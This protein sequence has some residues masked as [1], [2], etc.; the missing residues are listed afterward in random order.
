[1]CLQFAQVLKLPGYALPQRP[2]QG[3]VRQ[4]RPRASQHG[5]G[6]VRI[7][8]PQLGQQSAQAIEPRSAF[9][10]PA[11][12]QSMYHQPRLLLNALVTATNRSCGW[13]TAAQIAAASLASFFP[14]NRNGRTNS[15]AMMRAV[16]PRAANS[17]AN[18]CALE[19]ASIPTKQGGRWTDQAST[20]SRRNVRCTT[21]RPVAS[22]PHSETTRFARSSPT[23]VISPMTSPLLD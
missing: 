20:A 10:L 5:L 3:V 2:G 8:P 11:L 18:Q 4:G 17:R 21:T 15:G 22:S 12:A 1:V 9:L 16:W 23:V 7:D 19:Q 14:D 6:A 13:R